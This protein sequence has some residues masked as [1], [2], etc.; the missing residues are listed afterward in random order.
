MFLICGVD[1]ILT[2]T[3]YCNVRE[4]VEKKTIEE[5]VSIENFSMSIIGRAIV[6]FV[7]YMRAMMHQ[8]SFAAVRLN[9]RL[10]HFIQMVVQSLLR[11]RCLSSFI[12]LA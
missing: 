10:R 2:D 7:T 6:F 3:L 4:T 1:I 5:V 12:S 9:I 8:M 11:Q